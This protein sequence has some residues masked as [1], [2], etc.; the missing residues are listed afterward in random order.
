M[1]ALE[2]GSFGLQIGASST[3]LVLLFMADDSVEH[4]LNNDFTLGGDASAGL[5]SL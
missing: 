1:M 5:R 2:G 4:L 3:D